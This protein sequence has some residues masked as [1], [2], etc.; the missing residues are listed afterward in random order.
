MKICRFIQTHRFHKFLDPLS[1]FF[2]TR[3]SIFTI[4]SWFA[5]FFS[6]PPPTI[7]TK[8]I[9]GLQCTFGYYFSYYSLHKFMTSSVH[10][11]LHG[12]NL[13]C[14]ILLM[15]VFPLHVYVSC[16]FCFDLIFFRKKHL[17][18]FCIFPC[19]HNL[20]L[21]EFLRRIKK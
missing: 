13:N 10:T 8:K 16:S 21:S 1:E 12:V 5:Y 3:W 7:A 6:P 15:F 17:D 9:A 11:I 18:L 14:Y 20:C 4:K 19:M 2:S